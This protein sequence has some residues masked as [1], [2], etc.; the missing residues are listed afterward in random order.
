M[1]KIETNET[2]ILQIHWMK[3][4]IERNRDENVCHRQKHVI[5]LY[6][7]IWIA[8]NVC[9]FFCSF[10]FL[11]CMHI[12]IIVSTINRWL[13]ARIQRSVALWTCL[14]FN[15]MHVRFRYDSD[16]T[17]CCRRRH[18]IVDFWII[19]FFFSLLWLFCVVDDKL[20]CSTVKQCL[21]WTI[22]IFFFP[23]FSGSPGKW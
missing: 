23:S 7:A 16:S 21:N 4:A 2:F 22:Y 19:L 11:L 8:T 12:Q 9:I 18:F 13:A 6:F 15:W 20:I 5:T 14:C 10:F 3:N 1:H 17:V